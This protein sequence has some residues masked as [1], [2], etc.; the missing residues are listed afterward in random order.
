M[1]QTPSV[2]H[3]VAVEAA[4]RD[5]GQPLLVRKG[6]N[7]IGRFL[8]DVVIAVVLVAVAAGVTYGAQAIGATDRS[9]AVVAI[10]SLIFAVVALVFA[11]L[12]LVRGFTAH[13]LY[14]RGLVQTRNGRP[15]VA[16]WAD[17]D[18]V[19]QVRWTSIGS[20]AHTRVLMFDGRSWKIEPKA[21]DLRDQLIEMARRLD[22]PV[23]QRP[24]ADPSDRGPGQIPEQPGKLVIGV[25]LVGGLVIGFVLYRLGLSGYLGLS[26]GFWIVGFTTYLLGTRR[27]RIIRLLG[28]IFII[29]GGLIFIGFTRSLL[30]AV[31][32]WVV[33]GLT[34]GVELAVLRLLR[35]AYIRVL[36]QIGMRARA[37][38]ARSQGWHFARRETI[39]LPG[40]YTAAHLMN[41]LPSSTTTT[42]QGVMR[43]TVNGVPVLIF[44]RVRVKP[45]LEDYPQ[46][47]WM[48]TLP[49][50]SPL[51]APGVAASPIVT[52]QAVQL[53][54]G[55]GFPERWWI[56]GTVLCAVREADERTGIDPAYYRTY[57]RQLAL[58]AAELD[59]A[60][61]RGSA[62]AH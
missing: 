37:R 12:A 18:E 45:T 10:A 53:A 35:H 32:G 54:S 49:V 22:R 29:F 7:P 38:F 19:H 56:E 55:P 52:P 46:T 39:P 21:N 27:G 60:A 36:P 48:V 17:L 3:R 20:P 15:D 40:P 4:A 24:H 44:D 34:I 2:P 61:L 13:Y 31:N 41:V 26:L 42:G 51:H 57:G 30:A 8:L 28:M 62:Q 11:A 47:V 23:W 9:I 58:L 33:A 16:T 43:T 1:S 50:A 5:L 14:E 25:P 6:P 59:W